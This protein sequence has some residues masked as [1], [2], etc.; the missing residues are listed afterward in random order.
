MDNDI[1]K[2]FEQ[3]LSTVPH[4]IYWAVAVCVNEERP[5]VNE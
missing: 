4:V 1:I 5:F 2:I 3:S